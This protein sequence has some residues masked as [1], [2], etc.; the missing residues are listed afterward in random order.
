MNDHPETM[1][2][3]TRAEIDR[4]E[5]KDFALGPGP[6]RP[7]PEWA[8]YRFL[9]RRRHH[10]AGIDE[11]WQVLLWWLP[12]PIRRDYYLVQQKDGRLVSV[13]RDLETNSWYRQDY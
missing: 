8:R 9:A 3:L 5:N 7:R 13:F 10:V 6:K 11:A 2:G 4:V 12:Q 1:A